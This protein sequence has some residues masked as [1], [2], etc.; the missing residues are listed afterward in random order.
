MSLTKRIG[1]LERASGQGDRPW[2]PASAALAIM[3]ERIE[4]LRPELLTELAGIEE[5]DL[6][7]QMAE[8]RRDMAEMRGDYE[9]TISAC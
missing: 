3:A 7:Q 1:A 4:E 6:N 2:E 8:L 5:G 9:H